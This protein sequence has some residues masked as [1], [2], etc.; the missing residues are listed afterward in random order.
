MGTKDGGGEVAVFVC[1]A[2]SVEFVEQGVFVEGEFGLLVALGLCDGSTAQQGEAIFATSI[3]SNPSLHGG[4]G[5]IKESWCV[6]GFAVAHT[7]G[8]IEDEDVSG[9]LG[10]RGALG[11]LKEGFGKGKGQPSDQQAAQEQ[12]QELFESQTAGDAAMRA[13][14]KFHRGKGPTHRTSS[15]DQVDQDGDADREQSV[16]KDRLKKR[17][18][19]HAEAP[20]WL[21]GVF[22]RV[23]GAGSYLGPLGSSVYRCG[24]DGR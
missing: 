14:Q 21:K 20:S 3:A 15:A 4:A 11:A 6:G 23:R 13:Q 18:S 10:R 2:P 5:A 17:D 1:D 16:E 8:V 22:L 19:V 24:S 9:R 7:H 12:E